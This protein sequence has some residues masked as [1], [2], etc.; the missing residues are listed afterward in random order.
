M[1]AGVALVLGALAGLAIGVWLTSQ[2]GCCASLGKAALGKYGIPD[3][4]TGIDSAAG[5]FISALGL[6]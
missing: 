2:P 1:S 3:L 5:G 6:A 4:G